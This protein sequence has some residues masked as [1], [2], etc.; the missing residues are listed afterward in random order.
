MKKQILMRYV[1]KLMVLLRMW[2][3]AILI[4]RSLDMHR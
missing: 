4:S 3:E 1:K 2:G